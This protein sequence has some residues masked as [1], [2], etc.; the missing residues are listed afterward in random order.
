MKVKFDSWAMDSLQFIT[1]S[2][3]CITNSPIQEDDVWST[4]MWSNSLMKQNRNCYSL[5]FIHLIVTT[6]RLLIGTYLVEF[7]HDVKD[8]I[9]NNKTYGVPNIKTSP[10]QDFAVLDRLSR[11]KPNAHFIAL[12]SMIS[13]AYNKTSQWLNNLWETE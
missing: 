11:E 4:L 6:Q 1:N 3:L 2:S 8:E 13:F 7:Y 9:L 12:A 5:F 10:E